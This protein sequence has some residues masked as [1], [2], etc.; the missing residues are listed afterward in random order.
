M[1]NNQHEGH[2]LSYCEQS[3]R[4]WI[5]KVLDGGHGVEFFENTEELIDIAERSLWCETCGREI[6]PDEVGL[7]TPYEAH[8]A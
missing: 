4:A 3:S 1:N 6:D 5:C 8:P 7:V 2:T